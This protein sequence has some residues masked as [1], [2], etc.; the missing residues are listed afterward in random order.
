MSEKKEYLVEIERDDD[1]F[2]R[3]YRT[4]DAF[5]AGEAQACAMDEIEPHELIV[6]VYQRV[7]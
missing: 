6:A 1:E 4:Y 5:S 2:G 3:Y 7:L